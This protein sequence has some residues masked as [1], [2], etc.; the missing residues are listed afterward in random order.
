[1]VIVDRMVSRA[2]SPLCIQFLYKFRVYVMTPAVL[3]AQIYI[4][5]LTYLYVWGLALNSTKYQ[6]RIFSD[7]QQ[8][9]VITIIMVK[10]LSI[11]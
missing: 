1:M 5:N 11:F 2:R 3:L 4:Q 9:D 8:E 7:K 10:I 6:G